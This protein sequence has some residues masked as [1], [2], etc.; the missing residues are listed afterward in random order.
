M[1]IGN[2]SCEDEKVCP[3]PTERL[4]SSPLEPVLVLL[5]ERGSD[6]SLTEADRNSPR[7]GPYDYFVRSS[8][9]LING[10]DRVTLQSSGISIVPG[11]HPF[12]PIPE[13]ILE[14][15]IQKTE[16]GRPDEN[17]RMQ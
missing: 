9:V 6:L 11:V 17:E 13:L 5:L 1:L 14:S 8:T 7:N 12:L 2:A 4:I 3:A 10:S 15:R 16:Y